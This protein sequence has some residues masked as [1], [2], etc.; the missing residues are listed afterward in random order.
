MKVF[1][2]ALNVGME[3]VILY[4]SY[5]GFSSFWWVLFHPYKGV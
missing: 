3:G 1:S 4:L 5:Y 2:W